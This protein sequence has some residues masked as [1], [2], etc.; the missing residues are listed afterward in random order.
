L[1][2]GF[3]V[4]K[5]AKTQNAFNIGLAKNWL[6]EVIELLLCYFAS[7]PADGIKF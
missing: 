3:F 1:L 5:K 7:V 4:P 2:K 6:T